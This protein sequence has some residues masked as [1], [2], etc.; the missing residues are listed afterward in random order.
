MIPRILGC[1]ISNTYAV[2][3]I[4]HHRATTRLTTLQRA[5][6]AGLTQHRLV[7][8]HLQVCKDLTNPNADY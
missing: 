4:P 1:V 7:Q 5:K 8:V 2:L 6:W 3:L